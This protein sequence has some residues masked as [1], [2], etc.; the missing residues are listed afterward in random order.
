ME[1]GCLGLFP[2]RGDLKIVCCV[3]NVIQL[4]IMTPAFSSCYVLYWNC[5]GLCK[6]F[7]L[8]IVSFVGPVNI[9]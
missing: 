8:K 5:E 2:W 1:M 9:W 4:T 3:S 6:R 7:A